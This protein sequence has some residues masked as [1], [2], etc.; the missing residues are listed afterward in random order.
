[1]DTRPV[2]V[3]E[4]QLCGNEVELGSGGLLGVLTLRHG[5][6]QFQR[7]LGR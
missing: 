7:L 2:Q 3:M 5:T 1:M 6:Q 4:R